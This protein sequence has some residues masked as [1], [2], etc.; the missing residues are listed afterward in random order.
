MHRV[1]LDSILVKQ[2]EAL[3]K[4]DIISREV[5]AVIAKQGPLTVYELIKNVRTKKASRPSVHRRLHG[6]GKFVGLLGNDFLR[7]CKLRRFKKIK[8][9][10]KKF[11]GL[12]FKGLLASLSNMRLEETYLGR[13]FFNDIQ[14]RCGGQEIRDLAE[15]YI[16][17]ELALWMQL[18]LEFKIFLTHLKSSE[19][20]YRISRSSLFNLYPYKLVK[21]ENGSPK[22][23]TDFSDET[24]N[25]RKTL[26]IQGNILIEKLNILEPK[27]CNALK[28]EVGDW[29]LYMRFL[30][31][32]GKEALDRQLESD[33]PLGE[34]V[35]FTKLSSASL[36]TT[37]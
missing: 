8:G 6:E 13:P 18:H 37:M 25:L 15:G 34:P 14:Q 5:L 27:L 21:N 31:E 11:Y 9:V 33:R 24:R 12:T 22:I 3:F 16:K 36:T 28:Y 23:A 35:F 20:W 1:N 10:W 29:P 30:Q 19:D 7:I 17:A 32:F 26:G 2:S 4:I